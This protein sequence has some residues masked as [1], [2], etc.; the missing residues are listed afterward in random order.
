MEETSKLDD[1][2]SITLSSLEKAKQNS[3]KKIYIFK[4]RKQSANTKEFHT[5]QNRK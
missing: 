1:M 4:E 3:K 2:A 5:N